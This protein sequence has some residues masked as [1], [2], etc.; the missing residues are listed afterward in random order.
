MILSNEYI[1]LLGL[2]G[3]N[4]IWWVFNASEPTF[5]NIQ[6]LQNNNETFQPIPHL[7]TAQGIFAQGINITDNV[8]AF[9][10]SW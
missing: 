10:P 6:L 3:P 1:Y 9:T 7:L 4:I 8:M 2:T 5:V